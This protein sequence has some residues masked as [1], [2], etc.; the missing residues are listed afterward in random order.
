MAAAMAGADRV[1]VRARARRRRLG[2]RRLRVRR[3]R[4]RL[5]ARAAGAPDR[6]AQPDAAVIALKRAPPATA[7]CGEW[8]RA[9]DGGATGATRRT[10]AWR[11]RAR[12]PTT[13]CS[14]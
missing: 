5:V 3:D 9:S 1:A 2:R 4:A 14:G 13:T 11:S 6:R 10:T 7:A 12:R 8:V